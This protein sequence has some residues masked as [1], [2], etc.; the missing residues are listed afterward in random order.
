MSLDYTS[1]TSEEESANPDEHQLYVILF[2]SFVLQAI[3]LKVQFADLAWEQRPKP[4]PT[5]CLSLV[6]LYVMT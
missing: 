2:S 3:Y 6:N 4:R 5:V 1:W